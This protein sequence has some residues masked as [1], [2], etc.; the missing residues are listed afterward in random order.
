MCQRRGRKLVWPGEQANKLAKKFAW[1]DWGSRKLYKLPCHS[2]QIQCMRFGGE[3]CGGRFLS[4]HIVGKPQKGNQFFC[5]ET[6]LSRHHDLVYGSRLIRNQANSLQYEQLILNVP[7]C[8]V[9]FQ[10]RRF[11]IKIVGCITSVQARKCI[12]Q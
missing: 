3:R 10:N 9:L 8:K 7:I 6:D 12:C 11:Q 1:G 4:N 2:F 5:G